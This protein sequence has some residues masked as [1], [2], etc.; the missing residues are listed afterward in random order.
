MITS[1]EASDRP[2]YIALTNTDV[3][4]SLPGDTG[5]RSLVTQLPFRFV[6]TCRNECSR[7]GVPMQGIRENWI[8]GL[9]TLVGLFLV[10]M[11]VGIG[12]DDA[13]NGA[14]RFFGV[15]VMGVAA[16]AFLGGLWGLRSGRLSKAVSNAGIVVGVAGTVIWFWMIIPPALGLIVLWFGVARGGLARELT[17]AP[18]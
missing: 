12:V 16:V 18:A 11:T 9:A 7:R 3:S 5:F 1:P 10:F 15:A 4:P 14:E 6:C 13:S 2:I 17:V 8:T